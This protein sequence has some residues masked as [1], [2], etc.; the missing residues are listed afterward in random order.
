MGRNKLLLDLGGET[1]V[2]RT[3]GAALAAGL[4]PVI[5]LL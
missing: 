3:V 1:V 2:R 4:H 5:A